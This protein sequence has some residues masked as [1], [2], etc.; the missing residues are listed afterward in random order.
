[1][2]SLPTA[3]AS[4]SSINPSDQ[5]GRL[6]VFVQSPPREAGGSLDADWQI[7]N[8]YRGRH[9]PRLARRWQGDLLP[10]NRRQADG[11]AVESG[12]NLFR[13]R[14]PKPLFRTSLYTGSVSRGYDVTAD[15]QRF[16]VNQRTA[17]T[18]DIP[19][20]VIVNWPKLLQK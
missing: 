18:G 9:P 1:M 13:P 15:G 16:L 8:L 11:C 3:S 12:V 20:T 17:E 14:A 10:G 6:E 19:I 2:M 7:P 5:A 4:S